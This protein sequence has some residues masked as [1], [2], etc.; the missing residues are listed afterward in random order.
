VHNVI[1]LALL[2]FIGA[3]VYAGAILGLFGKAWLRSFFR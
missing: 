1:A 3:I 2:A